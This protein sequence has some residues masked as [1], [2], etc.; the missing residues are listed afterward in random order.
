MKNHIIELVKQEL[1]ACGLKPAGYDHWQLETPQ[2]AMT[3]RYAEEPN[4]YF[5]CEW[6]EEGLR[7]RMFFE[8]GGWEFEDVAEAE[9]LKEWL[10]Y[11]RESTV[12]SLP[13]AA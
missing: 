11:Y 10:L 2:G 1:A 5:E 9:C 7:N 3:V 4:P 13:L 6:S 8:F 12:E